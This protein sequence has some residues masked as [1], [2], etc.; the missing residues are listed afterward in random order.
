MTDNNIDIGSIIKNLNFNM[1][2][3]AHLFRAAQEGIAFSLK[4]GMD[5]MK[6]TGIETDVIRAGN[7][8]MFLSDLFSRTLATLTGA[9][10]E[11]Y[12][13]DGS[14]G[15]ARG[16]AIGAGLFSSPKE[17][18]AG[19]R[20]IKRIE[21]DTKIKSQIHDSF[22]VWKKYLLKNINSL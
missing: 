21:P 13:T 11:L 7:T 20:L 6:G 16:A 4:Y 5:V 1:H 17:A 9:V 19:L 3:K 10:I 15:A 22:E 14:L 18:F 8:N 2:H 12:N